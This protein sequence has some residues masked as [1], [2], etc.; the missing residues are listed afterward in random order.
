V[1][2]FE[3]DFN[4]ISETHFAKTSK[5]MCWILK[6]AQ[7]QRV[8]RRCLN[9]NPPVRFK[10]ILGPNE[11]SI[12][13]IDPPPFAG[14]HQLAQAEAHFKRFAESGGAHLDNLSACISHSLKVVVH[15]PSSS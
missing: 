12:G 15:T 14:I 1:V 4:L 8:H 7:H 11:H 10:S 9:D 5:S 13:D 3:V 2:D 6:G